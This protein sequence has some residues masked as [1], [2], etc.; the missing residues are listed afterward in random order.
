VDRK[1]DMAVLAVDPG[2]V[3]VPMERGRSQDLRIGHRVF[4]FGSPLGIKFSMS[5]GIVSGMGRSDG[6]Q[7]VRGIRGYTNYIQSDAAINP[8]NSGGPLVDVNGN[9]VG[10]NTS[11][12][13]APPSQRRDT[14]SPSGQ[15]AG[16]GFAIP[17]ETA[18]AVVDQ[19]LEHEVILRGYLGMRPADSRVVLRDPASGAVLD[20]GVPVAAV[21]RGEPAHEAGLRSGDVIVQIAGSAT[22][23]FDILRSV[24]S[25]L[26]PGVVAEVFINR[27]GERLMVPVRIGAAMDV[28]NG[29]RYIPGSEGMGEAEIRVRAQRLLD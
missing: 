12:A 28:G 2:R 19:L 29:L 4:A 22:R 14:V 21:P 1:T 8:G 10:M 15:S 9:I 3:V 24:V 6:A 17:L 26:E 23:D 27:E 13:N 25:V 16:I 5:A 20:Q 11:I 7:F 18:E